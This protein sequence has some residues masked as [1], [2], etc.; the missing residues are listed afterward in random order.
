MLAYVSCGVRKARLLLT[1]PKVPVRLPAWIML[2]WVLGAQVP[3]PA[4]ML[5]PAAPSE[6]VPVATTR[7]ERPSGS[8]SMTSVEPLLKLRSPST[9]RV[10]MELP[11]FRAAPLARL[12]S[13]MRVPWPPSMAP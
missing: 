4:R 3:L 6:T 9:F 12:T 11:G 5:R 10:P 8:A 2:Y 13:P 7:S 1:L